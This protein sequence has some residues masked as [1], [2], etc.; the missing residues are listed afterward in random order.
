MTMPDGTAMSC[1][2]FGAMVTHMQSNPM[3]F[4]LT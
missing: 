4:E 1:R 3:C 2:T